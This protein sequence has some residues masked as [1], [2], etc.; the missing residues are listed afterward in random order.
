MRRMM[1]RFYL[2]ATHNV[3]KRDQKTLNQA[4]GSMIPKERLNDFI[5]VL[6]HMSDSTITNYINSIY[7]FRL[8]DNID[9]QNTEIYFYH[10]TAVNEIIARKS[11]K[12]ISKHYPGAVIRCLKGKSHCETALFQPDVMI[13][14]LDKVLR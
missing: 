12:F 11:A 5:Q 14:E 10:G 4:I 2:K 7:D 9:A 1:L 6:D 13:K 8:Q 3:Q